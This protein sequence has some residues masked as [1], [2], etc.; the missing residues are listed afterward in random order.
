M[1]QQTTKMDSHV[2]FIN[3]VYDKVEEP[4]N[5]VLNKISSISSLSVQNKGMILEK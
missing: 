5:Y 3:N 4:M 1:E 2:D